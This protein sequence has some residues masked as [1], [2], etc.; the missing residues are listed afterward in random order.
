MRH[1][2]CFWEWSPDR[3][4]AAIFGQRPGPPQT[5][6]QADGAMPADGRAESAGGQAGLVRVR[7]AGHAHWRD[8]APDGGAGGVA[9]GW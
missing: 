4:S 9:Q 5:L 8:G 1:R 3:G 7:A 2:I 6:R